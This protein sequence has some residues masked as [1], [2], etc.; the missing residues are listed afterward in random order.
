MRSDRPIILTRPRDNKFDKELS[1]LTPRIR[2]KSVRVTGCRY[3]II[4]RVSR[5]A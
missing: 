2:S 3:A 5:L 1:E 4:A